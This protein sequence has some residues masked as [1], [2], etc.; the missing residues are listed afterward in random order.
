M[1]TEKNENLREFTRV[2]MQVQVDIQFGPTLTKSV[3]IQDLS[4]NGI[5]VECCP[6]FP[7]G[8]E[9]DLKETEKEFDHHQGLKKSGNISA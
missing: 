9:A 6:T 8:S 5:F 4:M 1:N 7:I 3:R 2:S